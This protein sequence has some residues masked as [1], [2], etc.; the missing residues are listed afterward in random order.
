MASRS[1]TILVVKLAV[2][3]LAS[4]RLVSTQA[5]GSFFFTDSKS[6]AGTGVVVHN[7][8]D[9]N[10]LYSINSTRGFGDMK[11]IDVDILPRNGT[12]VACTGYLAG[13]SVYGAAFYQAESSGIV[14]LFFKCS[15]KAGTCV[16][17]GNWFISNSVTIPV[18][19]TTQ[20]TAAIFPSNM[21]YRVTYQDTQGALRQLAY[22]NGT[23][24]E[25][26]WADGNLTGNYTIPD[27]YAFDTTTISPKNETG[28][29]LRETIYAVGT[30]DIKV[31]DSTTHNTSGLITIDDPKTWSANTPI[32]DISLPHFNNSLSHIA[33]V[34]YSNWDCIFYIDN[35][36]NLQFVRSTDGGMKYNQQPQM[37][38][39]KW[40]QADRPNAPITASV[41][42]NPRDKSAYVFYKSNG[43]Y[44][45]A[46]MK[47]SEWEDR[48]IVQFLEGPPP[49]EPPKPLNTVP[50]KKSSNI[51]LRIKIG[52]GIGGAVSFLVILAILGFWYRRVQIARRKARGVQKEDSIY[53]QENGSSEYRFAGKA[54]LSG[55]SVEKAEL[56]HDP[57]C[58]LLHQLQLR[59]LAEL[60]GEIPEELDGGIAVHRGELD[61]GEINN[62]GELAADIKRWESDPGLCRCHLDG[63]REEIYELASPVSEL[64]TGERWED[65]DRKMDAVIV[66]NEL[67]DEPEE[68]VVLETI[69]LLG[70]AS[71]HASTSR[72]QAGES[73][74]DGDNDNDE[75][76]KDR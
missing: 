7:P 70:E 9:D 20:L 54:E 41:S 30:G 10:F 21:G 56:D 72:T 58:L 55:H 44:I 17:Y 73:G 68:V 62:K 5:I 23:R 51:A 74:N 65:G 32:P 14:Q 38:L 40:P 37:A 64:E 31:S 26:T 11:A 63:A 75:K 39:E 18:S 53:G 35:E 52:A 61:S 24:G 34:S 33:T 25:T 12:P 50:A 71:T 28:D 42:S 13:D 59:R 19:P 43:T 76:G 22:A 4:S 8:R 29:R 15:Y 67:S 57:N 48:Q 3:L 2:V 36:R 6:I 69:V 27:G 1:L 16:N 60:R 49:I 46:K 47:N 45:Q 66:E